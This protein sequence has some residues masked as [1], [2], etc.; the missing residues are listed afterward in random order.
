MV[1]RLFPQM[2]LAGNTEELRHLHH[3]LDGQSYLV[4][5]WQRSYLGRRYMVVAWHDVRR[6]VHDIL[7]RLYRDIDP[8]SRIFEEPVR[9][10]YRLF[11]RTLREHRQ[12]LLK[13]SWKDTLNYET[14]WMTRDD[15]VNATYD[16]A[17]LLLDL[18]IAYGIIDRVRG[19]ELKGHIRRAKELIQRLDALDDPREMGS[20]L[21]TE[22]FALNRSA[23]LCD[24]RELDWPIKGWRFNLVRAVKILFGSL[25]H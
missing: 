4:S 19:A 15:I 14:N 22:I 13:P 6:V 17:L 10:G 23:S 3:V 21:R 1:N 2:N 5:Y 7:P 25:L 9:F 24:K 12:A 20:A 11:Y 16:G 8:G 18:K